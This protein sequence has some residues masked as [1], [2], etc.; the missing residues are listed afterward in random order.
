VPSLIEFATGRIRSSV[1]I[2]LKDVPL[3]E[4]MT[5]RVGL[6]VYVENDASCAA[7]A[8]A[9]HDGRM[10]VPHLVMFTVGTG[11]GGGLVLNGRLYRG[12]TGAASEV[13]HTVIGLDLEHGAPPHNGVFPQVGSL[14]VLASGR[15]LDQLADAAARDDANSF[16]GRRSGSRGGV[17]GHD[18]VDGAREGDEASIRCLRILGERLG[19]GIA[20]AISMFDPLEV[21]IGGGVS[22][23]GDLL[24]GPARENARRHVVPGAGSKTTLRLARHGPRAGVLG[25]AL[26]A[27]Q[28]WAE[29]QGKSSGAEVAASQDGG[30]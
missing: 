24:L 2:P 27:A 9:F 11:V 13:G 22:A 14:E 17:T 28:E 10:A 25:A 18:V 7:L 29:E 23:A 6:P 15:A 5:D 16:L 12:A 20:N 1:N 8:E 21:V 26:I 4:L 30:A 3:R 19:I